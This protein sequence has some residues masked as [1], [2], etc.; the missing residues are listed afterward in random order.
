MNLLICADPGARLGTVANWLNNSLECAVFEPGI[1]FKDVKYKKIHTDFQNTVAKNYSGYKIRIRPSFKKLS[2]HLYLFLLKNV[3]AQIK[4]FSKNPYDLETAT[5]VICS[6]QDWFLHDQQIDLSI[7]NTVCN[8]E[9]TYNIDFMIEIY[10]TINNCLPSDKLINILLETNKLNDPD[11]DKN[12]ACV[13][14]AMIMQRE[15]ELGLKEKDRLW[16]LPLTYTNTH[17]EALY[18]T[19][20]N[21][22]TINNYSS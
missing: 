8:F 7:Y 10:Q 12:Y 2:T 13:I 16:S 11:L 9:D 18:D 4:G 22:I 15:H 3:Y 5:K 19:I 1:V 17:Q 6:A 20:Y 14:A 21:C